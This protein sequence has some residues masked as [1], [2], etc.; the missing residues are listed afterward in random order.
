MTINYQY[1]DVDGLKLR[2]AQRNKDAQANGTLLIFNGVGAA[3]EILTPLLKALNG[4]HLVTFDLPGV[5]RSEA[6][7]IPK[8][9]RHYAKMAASV[10]SELDVKQVNVMGVSWG[11][12]LAQQFALQ[13]PDRTDKLILAATSTGQL[14]V[15]PNPLVMWRMMTP[16]RYFSTG[17][18][19]YVVG[20]IYGGD[21]RDA[22]NGL[23]RQHAKR[24]TPPSLLGYFQQ[25]SALWG[26]TSLHRLPSLKTPTLI[27][28][29]DDDP[30]IPLANARI[31][32]RLIPNSHLEIFNCG[33]LFLLT[34]QQQSVAAI[35]KF[36]Q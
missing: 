6:P 35:E 12:M 32:A 26:W 20:S 2:V 4:F 31:M 15:P 27:M 23:A 19:E 7:T 8:R 33:H 5:G 1:L 36:L 22:S 13:F 25:S 18:F 16:L 29:G 21:F 11:G 30:I 10:L 34:R 14:M 9:L 24:M 17:Y 3:I 28:A